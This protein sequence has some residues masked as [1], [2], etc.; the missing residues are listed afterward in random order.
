MNKNFQILHKLK[1]VIKDKRNA[2]PSSS[3]TAGLFEQGKEKIANKFGEEAFETVTAFLSQTKNDLSQET[4]DLIYH[5]FVL[6]ESAEV[7]FDNVTQILE[8]R[9]KENSKND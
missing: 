7:D 1:Q 2:S 9:M 8:E 4:A 3:Y 6:L 5:L